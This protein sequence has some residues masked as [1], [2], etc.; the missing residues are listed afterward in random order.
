MSN[1][2]NPLR[3]PLEDQMT[4]DDEAWDEGFAV[5]VWDQDGE[6]HAMLLPRGA[7]ALDGEAREVVRLLS[8]QAAWMHEVTGYIEELVHESRELGVSWSV[9]GWAVGTTGEAARQRWG[10]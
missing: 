4:W 9:I 1:R 7:R 2:R 5:H 10:K 6:R 8:R 3:P